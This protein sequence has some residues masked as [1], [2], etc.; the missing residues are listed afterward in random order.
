MLSGTPRAPLPAEV[1]GAV[2]ELIDELRSVDPGARPTLASAAG[3]L[4]RLLGPQ[5]LFAL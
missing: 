5:P 1:P 3:R 2:A 4:A